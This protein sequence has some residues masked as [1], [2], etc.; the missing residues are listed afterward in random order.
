[1]RRAI[2]IILIVLAVAIA[3]TPLPRG[4]VERLFSQGLYPIIQPRL[5]ALSNSTSFAWFDLAVLITA[6][7]I[8]LMWAVRLFRV[9]TLFSRGGG[10]TFVD[11]RSA[12]GDRHR[13]HDDDRRSFAARGSVLAGLVLDTAVIA[14]FMYLWFL[15]VWGL[16]YQREPLRAHLDFTEDRITREA[17]RALAVKNVELLNDL[18]ADAHGR[19][20]PELADV[21][22]ALGP[23]FERTQRDL[24]MKWLATAGRPKRSLLDF[25][26]TRVSIDG[27]TDP[28]FLEALA[29][30]SL[31]PFERHFT[32]AHEWGH[33]AG[34][35]DESEANFVGWLVCMRGPVAAQYSAWLGLHGTIMNALPRGDRDGIS[36]HLAEGPREDLRAIAERLRRQTVPM[37]RLASNA[38]YDRF[39]KAN[40]VEAGI[41]SYSEVL[42]LLLGTRFTTDGAPVLRR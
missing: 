21:P 38:M 7:A 32:V 23:A 14:A 17:L 35:A 27:M 24:G 22:A 5:T 15:A 9:R 39:L 33:L 3:V 19:R 10:A 8:L 42:Q 31:L 4:R 1:M 28:F 36:R 2:K 29:I 26:F 34:H 37:A 41:R 18:H 30:Q 13:G 6:S 16:N 20:W 12:I 40:R 25:Y 11:R